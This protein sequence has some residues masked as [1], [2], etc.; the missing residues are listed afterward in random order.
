MTKR[1]ALIIHNQVYAEP[2]L[3]QLKLPAADT[4]ALAELLRDPTVGNFDEVELA[5]NSPAAE[6]RQRVA[7]LFQRKHRHDELLLYIVGHLLVDEAGQIHLAAVDTRLDTL[8]ETTL[9]T[10]Y[11][12]DC[13]D[14]SFSRRQMLLLNGGCLRLNSIEWAADMHPTTVFKG[15]G[16]GRVVLTSV[17]GNDSTGEEEEAGLTHHLFQALQTGAADAD[18]DGQVE[19]REL[20]QYLR[21]QIPQVNLRVYG[22]HEHFI[23]ARNPYHFIPA[24]PIKWDLI[25]GAILAPVTIIIIGGRADLRTAIGMA[26]LLLL[27]YAL[28]YLAPD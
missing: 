14:R 15:R 8:T 21:S 11:L 16:Y 4:A 17:T 25:S 13:M 23:L 28:L 12:T 26:G 22:K 2:E 19:L 7:G 18:T 24:Q 6:L 5:V 27:M 20:Y 1:I 3:A 9:S 10:A